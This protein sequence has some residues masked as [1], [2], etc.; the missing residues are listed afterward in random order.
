[1]SMNRQRIIEQANI[2]AGISSEF[3]FRISKP[4]SLK[5]I[6]WRQKQL[7]RPIPQ[8]LIKLATQVAS[9]IHLSWTLDSSK[10]ANPD[11]PE[12]FNYT[13]GFEF[14]F[15]ETDLAMLKSWE[16]CFT[17]WE[18]YGT[19]APLYSYEEIFPV[20]DPGN[21]DLIVC[22]IGKNETGA[23]YNICHDPAEGE[24][25]WI[26]LADSYE[27]FVL[28]LSQLWFPDLDWDTSLEHFYDKNNKVI[29][30]KSEAG[31]ELDRLIQNS[32]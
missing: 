23:L 2:L 4:A 12:P 28:T 29:S 10:A 15:F 6:A 16:D 26:K 17:N 14:N 21:G 18:D 11:S 30:F 13:G 7:E 25:G 31:L 1:M 9:R 27:Q 20:F 32:R 22:L 8:D 19:E 24:N 5:D 3:S